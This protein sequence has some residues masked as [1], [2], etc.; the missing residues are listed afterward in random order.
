MLG[1]AAREGGD[2]LDEVE[3]RLGWTPFLGEY[4]V[5]D[6]GGLGL[7]EPAFPQEIGAI[8]VRTRDDAFS[9][10]PD[11]VDE[12]Q[13]RGIGEPGQRRCRLVREA[14]GGVFTVPDADLLEILDAP[15]LRF[16][17]TARR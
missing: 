14:V 1:L 6:L 4:G 9:R 11:A 17:Q 13:R 7:P 15:R 10:L 8:P 12:W 5:D 3:H 16:W 2:A